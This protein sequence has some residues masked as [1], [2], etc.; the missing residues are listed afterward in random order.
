[1]GKATTKEAVSKRRQPAEQMPSAYE[2]FH[3][4]AGIVDSGGLQLSTRTGQRF[5]EG[6]RRKGI[7]KD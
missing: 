4:F 3:P 6:L 7:G 1:M 5:C 2:R